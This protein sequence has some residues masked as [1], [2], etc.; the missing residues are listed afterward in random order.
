V[1]EPV[2]ISPPTEHPASEAIHIRFD[3][4]RT[5]F[6]ASTWVTLAEAAAIVG[7]SSSTIRRAANARTIRGQRA[8]GSQNS[9][10]LVH[11][12]DVESRWSPEPDVQSEATEPVGNA[13]AAKRQAPS[14]PSQIRE[15]FLL[16][17]PEPRWWQLRGR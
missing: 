6:D 7:V 13:A 4:R 10:W 9:P 17:E 11:L 16:P 1:P 12:E 8:G 15:Q 3:D 14:L 5:A 2:E